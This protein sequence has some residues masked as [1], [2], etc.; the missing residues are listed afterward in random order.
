MKTLYILRGLP[1][2]GKSTLAQTIIGEK[3]VFEADQYFMVGGEY[4]F[5]PTKLHYAHRDCFERV[6]KWMQYCFPMAVANTFVRRSEYQ[7]YINLAASHGYDVQII[8][9]HG[10]WESVH[11]VP[12]RTLARMRADWEPHVRA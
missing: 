5:D 9:V 7:P 3:L 1:G 11:G 4:R 8:E 6:A 12:A 2:S 10:P